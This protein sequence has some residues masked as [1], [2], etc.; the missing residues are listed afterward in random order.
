MGEPA[1]I[2]VC[3]S[4]YLQELDKKFGE[5]AQYVNLMKMLASKNNQ[6]KKLREKV[7]Q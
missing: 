2:S 4:F 3:S 7:E 6:I 5:T 1:D